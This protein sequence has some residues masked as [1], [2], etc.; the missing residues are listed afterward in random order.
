MF[1][2]ARGQVQSAGLSDRAVLS[3]YMSYYILTNASKPTERRKRRTLPLLDAGLRCGS[4]SGRLIACLQ[5]CLQS[6]LPGNCVTQLGQTQPI[7]AQ[8]QLRVRA[9]IKMSTVGC[10][11][12]LIQ[13]HQEHRGTASDSERARTRRSLDLG[14]YFLIE[15][16]LRFQLTGHFCWI[17]YHFGLIPNIRIPLLEH[18]FALARR[19]HAALCE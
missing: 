9:C 8:Q 11:T 5:A 2:R 14:K 3:V 6:P 17:L 16:L 18:F 12:H 15:H 10:Q 7:R 19:A 4:S 1:Y 13:R